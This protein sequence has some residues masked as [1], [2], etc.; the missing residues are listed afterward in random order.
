MTTQGLLSDIAQ[1]TVNSIYIIKS[2]QTKFKMFV[3]AATEEI[4]RLT[5][6]NEELKNKLNEHSQESS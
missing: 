5:K 4:D 6:E 1:D 3:S 2:I